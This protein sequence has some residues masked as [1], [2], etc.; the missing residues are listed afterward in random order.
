MAI[1]QNPQI[2]NGAV[3]TGTGTRSFL[4][5]TTTTAVKSTAGRI[6]VVNVI[7]AGSGNGAVYDRATTSGVAVS[8]AVGIIPQAAGTY[9]FDFPC[10]NGIVVLPPTGSTITVSFN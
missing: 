2:Q 4:N 3:S 6:C 8:N 10:A 5:I 9:M 1:T 7:N